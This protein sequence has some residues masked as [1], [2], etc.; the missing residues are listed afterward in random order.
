MPITTKFFWDCE[1]ETNY[2]YTRWIKYC[3]ICGA[4]RDNQP[5]SMIEE[6]SPSQLGVINQ[7]AEMYL[8]S[9]EVEGK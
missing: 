4:I 8:D 5:D 7:Y 2:I 9:H 6:L 1:C 3:Q